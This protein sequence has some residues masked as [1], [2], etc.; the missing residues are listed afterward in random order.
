MRAVLTDIE[1]VAVP[2]A[3]CATRE[4]QCA[5]TFFDNLPLVALVHILRFFS[6]KP[7]VVSWIKE[8][9]KETMIEVSRN[10]HPLL[11][12]AKHAITKLVLAWRAKDDISEATQNILD[13]YGTTCVSLRLLI[14]GL[15]LV[16]D[17]PS[18]R[19]CSMLKKLVVY[20]APSGFSFRNLLSGQSNLEKLEFVYMVWDSSAGDAIANIGAG[21]KRLKL[22]TKLSHS[23]AL[24]RML[25]SVG[26]TLHSLE[27][28]FEEEE[29]ID[30]DSSFDVPKIAEFCPDITEICL[31]YRPSSHFRENE[32]ALYCKY[33][34]QLK[35]VSLIGRGFTKSFLERLSFRCP[36]VRVNA[37]LASDDRQLVM[38][39]LGGLICENSLLINSITPT[40]LRAVESK[41][42][43]IETLNIDTTFAKQFFI[44]PKTRLRCLALFSWDEEPFGLCDDD[45]LTIAR[46]TGALREFDWCGPRIRLQTMEVFAAANSGLEDVELFG[47]SPGEEDG[48]SFSVAYLIDMIR[49]FSVCQELSELRLDP[50]NDNDVPSTRNAAVEDACL[51]FR[52]RKVSVTLGSNQYN[53]VSR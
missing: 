14:T 40:A 2:V 9:K 3:M 13:F 15:P 46:S 1:R 41:A 4:A 21:L 19:K 31:D 53:V 17:A 52:F 18:V 7:F 50:C 25:Q 22:S 49:A 5:G 20:N 26:R 33:G 45:V 24:T 28:L 35:H 36:N 6:K 27:L 42:T 30:L 16:L 51:S 43:S 44:T 29:H 10:C 38:D 34:A 11:E 39:T 48:V 8:L 23:A 12:V 47:Y 32:I 37:F